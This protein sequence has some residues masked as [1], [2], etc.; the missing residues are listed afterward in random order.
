MKVFTFALIF[1]LSFGLIAQKDTTKSKLTFTGDFRFRVEQDWNSRKSDGIFR[2]DRTR[3]R[4]RFRFGMSYQYNDWASFG[5]RLRTGVRNHQQDPQITLGTNPGEFG[6]IPLGFEK[7]Y[8]KVD[9][10]WLSTWV[11][12][13]LFP[14][15][16]QNELFWSENVFPEGIFFSAKFQSSSRLLQSIKFGAGHFIINSENTSLD[17]DR[18]FEGI[19]IVTTHWNNRIILFPTLYYF[20][21]MPDIPD[22]QGT[23]DIDYSIFHIGTNVTIIQKPVLSIGVDYYYNFNDLSKND[24][25][26]QNLQDQKQGFVL[27]LVLGKF[28]EKKDWTIRVYYSYLQRY[29]AVDFLAQNDW[30]RW[31]YSDQGSPAGRLTNYQGL[32]LMAGYVINKNFKLNVRYFLVEQLI[33]YGVALETGSRIR[34]DLDIGF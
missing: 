34:L 9:H 11:G 4:Y 5:M 13:Y 29:S 10:K 7:L 33:P 15:E 32:E 18:Y 27:G 25:I 17:K 8:F 30:A 2:E 23:Y 3:L 24:S 26:P 22:G 31:D 28:E 16:H 19:Q 21:K 14:F 12:K 1:L 20:R 6:T